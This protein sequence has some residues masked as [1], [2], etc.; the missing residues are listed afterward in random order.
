MKSK[1]IIKVFFLLNII[2]AMQTNKNKNKDSTK[3]PE[4]K[5][6]TAWATIIN[7]MGINNFFASVLYTYDFF[8]K[9]IYK[10]FAVKGL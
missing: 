5:K 2:K 8:L 10:K 1:S 4:I 9:D 6:S 3:S 7:N